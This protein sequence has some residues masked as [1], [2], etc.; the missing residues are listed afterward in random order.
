MRKRGEAPWVVIWL[1]IFF[2]VLITVAII[3]VRVSNRLANV[4]RERGL[5]S[6]WEEIWEGE[7]DE[8]T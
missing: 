1:S 6:I 8:D 4:V 7:A 3:G 5:K 2:I